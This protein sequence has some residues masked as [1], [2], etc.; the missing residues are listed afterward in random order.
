MTRNSVAAVLTLTNLE[1]RYRSADEFALK[2]LNLSLAEREIYGLLGPNGCGKTTTISIICGLLQAGKGEVFLFGKD[3]KKEMRTIKRNIGYV[4]QEIALYPH[5]TLEENLKYFGTMHGIRGKRLTE[6]IRVCLEIAQLEKFADKR[7]ST[8]S[9]GMKR[10][11]NLVVGIINNPKML[12]LDEPTVG[13]DPQSKNAI[14]EALKNLREEGM[15]M[16]YTTHYMEEAQILCTRIGIMD[17]GRIISQ[18]TP[19]ELIRNTPH[20]ADIG[21]VFLALTGKQLRDESDT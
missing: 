19:D 10:R 14:F 21:E 6:R 12:F 9:G 18:G 5:L 16:I 3:V 13:V 2:G 4:P 15:T 7:V 8:F 11:S 17:N 1:M 20:C